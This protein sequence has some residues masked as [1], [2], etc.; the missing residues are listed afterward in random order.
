MKERKEEE[1]INEWLGEC[2][3]GGVCDEKSED[4]DEEKALSIVDEIIHA[5][6]EK[7]SFLKE[8]AISINCDSF[9]RRATIFHLVNLE[10]NLEMATF[11]RDIYLNRS[12]DE[13][14]RIGAYED[15]RYIRAKI[16]L[17]TTKA[18]REH[19]KSL[20]PNEP[21]ERMRW[22]MSLRD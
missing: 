15:Y 19:E 6:K 8:L 20:I 12:D 14:V 1:K 5:P 18:E 2:Q 4:Y 3:K 11:L 17:P 21:S 9:C 22:L 7:A 16:G 10:P 13:R